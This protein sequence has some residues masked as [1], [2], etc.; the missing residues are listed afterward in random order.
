MTRLPQLE[1]QLIAAAGSRRAR[2]RRRPALIAAGALVAAASVVLA[3]LLAPGPSTE[4]PVAVP[5][6]VPA[7][8]LV[9]A[10]A[11]AEQR[12]PLSRR[13]RDDQIA[14]VV[15]QARAR[16]PY[17]P[18]MSDR[19]D[20]FR[21]RRNFNNNVLAIH[22][23]IERRAYCLWIRYWVQGA[24][25]A[26]AAAVLAQYPHWAATRQKDNHLTYFQNKIETALRTH[27]MA[28]LGQEA[29]NC[30]AVG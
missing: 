23:S 14:A 10:R 13:V 4:R 21:H 19:F 7:A 9:K 5:Q 22:A 20:Y 25:R 26:G 15:K 18:G 8:T 24:D 2:M 28:V 30:A 3:L 17:P 6:T 1:A 27:D 11:L 12:R 16:T 29:S